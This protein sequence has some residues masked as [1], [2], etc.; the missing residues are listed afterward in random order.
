[1]RLISID[2][3]S[4]FDG[5][6]SARMLRLLC[7]WVLVGLLVACAG[8]DPKPE[9]QLAQPVASSGK[10][11]LT[12]EEQAAWN[13]AL[14]L[15]QKGDAPAAVS[16]FQ[17]IL[18]RQP[19]L[20]GAYVNLGILAEQRQDAA[21]A[22]QLYQQALGINPA[23]DVALMQLALLDQAQGKFR[24][25]EAGLLK[26]ASINGNN[27]SVHYNLGVLYELFLQNPGQALKHYRRYVELSNSE[28]KALVE[29]WILLLERNS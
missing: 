29:R 28:D 4:G 14:A 11:V 16:A 7:L 12:P 18:T 6:H 27:A 13:A 24:E 1:M 23:N 5:L 20:A 17:A 19:R 2:S 22:R 25:A 8:N 3:V 21:Q 15:M 26:V 9:A 10:P